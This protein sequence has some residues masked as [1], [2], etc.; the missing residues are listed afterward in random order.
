MVNHGLRPFTPRVVRVEQVP[1]G[2]GHLPQ[3]PQTPTKLHRP[4]HRR[5]SSPGPRLPTQPSPRPAGRLPPLP[6]RSLSGP[7]FLLVGC[8]LSEGESSDRGAQVGGGPQGHRR[9]RGCQGAALQ[10][11]KVALGQESSVQGQLCGPRKGRRVAPT[12]GGGQRAPHPGAWSR[13]LCPVLSVPPCALLPHSRP[14]PRP[15]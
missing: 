9:R 8:S 11:S 4:T 3:A 5:R 7:P 13:C 12:S 2:T 14:Q 15:A 6:A 10:G 1:L